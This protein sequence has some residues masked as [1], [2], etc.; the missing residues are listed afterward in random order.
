MINRA[1]LWIIA[2]VALLG[3]VRPSSAEPFTLNPQAVGLHGVSIT[4]GALV[5]SDYAQISFSNN[6]TTFV[7]TGILPI[8][9]FTLDGAPVTSPGYAAPDG[10]GW[11][12]Y[13]QYVGTGAEAYAAAGVPSAATFST[14]SYKI[15]GYNGLATFGFAPDGSAVVGGQVADSVAVASGS[16]I[17]GQLAF[18][19]GPAGLTIN[20]TAA[21]T[22]DTA[23][24]GFFQGTPSQIDV[25]FIHPPAEY[26]FTSQTT[27]EIDG[28]SSSSAV[29]A[30]TAVP[31]PASLPLLGLPL[32]GMA[33][34]GLARFTRRRGG[35]AGKAATRA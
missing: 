18:I 9:G 4:E 26:F 11:G 5:L 32:V 2:A 21:A 25:T 30:G 7:D 15:I 8:L 31:E 34:L 24:P 28:G 6:G 33:L 19:P 22:L 27:L 16:L 12:A 35:L 20:G 1:H 23:T 10:T 29:L 13:V 14:L 17:S 3:S